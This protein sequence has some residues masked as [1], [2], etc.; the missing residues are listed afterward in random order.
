M[1]VFEVFERTDAGTDGRP[2]PATSPRPAADRQHTLLMAALA[3]AVALI[4][5]ALGAFVVGA[6]LVPSQSNP[7]TARDRADRD[8]VTAWLQVQMDATAIEPGRVVLPTG[9]GG[10]APGAQVV[11]AASDVVDDTELDALREALAVTGCALDGTDLPAHC[12]T[13]TD[14]GMPV[15]VVIEAAPTP[16]APEGDYHVEVS[17]QP[18]AEST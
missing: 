16:G 14:T 18:D 11:G 13:A 12:T 8:E 2:L 9:C 10:S 4:A 17:R 3:G 5:L 15:L 6:I 1:D 7:C